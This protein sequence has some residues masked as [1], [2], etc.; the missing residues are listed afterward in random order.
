MRRR[1]AFLLTA[2]LLG[3]SPAL[4]QSPTEAAGLEGEHGLWVRYV[5]DSTAVSWIT[6]T[7]AAGFLE[8]STGRRVTFQTTTPAGSAHTAVFVTPREAALTLRYGTVGDPADRHETTIRRDDPARAPRVA[9]GA[10]DSLVV[11]SDIHGELERLV[12]VLRNAGVVD[13]DRR[14]SGGR[15]HLVVLGDIFDRGP[16]V[17]GSLWF[18]YRLESEAQEAGGRL[19]VVLGNHEI[20]V[21]QGDLRFLGERDPRVATRYGVSFDA[22]FRPKESVLARWL[23]GRP[24]LMRIGD[25]L[26]AHGGVSTDYA[27]WSV[28]QHL[29]TLRAYAREELFSR[30]ADSTYHPPLDSAAVQRRIDFLWGERSVFWYRATRRATRWKGT[31]PACSRIS[32]PASWSWATRPWRP[33]RSAMTGGSST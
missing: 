23:V 6:R 12:T 9:W 21:M 16:D 1:S 29:D 26:F 27:E 22:L 2:L 20:M 33:S 3:A 17:L 8:V 13:A 10:V 25:A 32:T 5:G 19:H 14:W 30:W 31:S 24:A 15:K 7:P 28:E 11:V 4:A 18:L